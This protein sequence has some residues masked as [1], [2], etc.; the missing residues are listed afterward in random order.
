MSSTTIIATAG[1]ALMS[2]TSIVTE[3]RSNEFPADPEYAVSVTSPRLGSSSFPPGVTVIRNVVAGPGQ[4]E[5][6]VTAD[7]STM[8]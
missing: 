2:A 3:A 1:S 8:V 6:I 5:L 4:S 7:W